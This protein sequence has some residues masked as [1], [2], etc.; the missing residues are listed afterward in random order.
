MRV[1]KIVAA[2][3]LLAVSGC[4]YRNVNAQLPSRKTII[5]QMR[6]V[7]NFQMSQ[8]WSTARRSN[9]ELVM[10]PKTWEAGAFYPGLLDAYR[11]THEKVYLNHVKQ[12][13]E[14][15]HYDHN[16]RI[17]VA[18]DIAILQTYLELYEFDRDPVYIRASRIALDSIMITP[19][20]GVREYGWCDLLF[21]GPPVWSRYYA[22]SKERKYIEY[23]DKI[24][25]EAVDN[26]KDK[27][28]HLFYRDDRF[29]TITSA[30]GKPVFWS[31]GNGWVMAGI[32][33]YLEYIPHKD[34][35]RKKYEALLS[36]MAAALK[37]LQQPDGFW[38]SNLLEPGLF[39]VGE[40]SGTVFFCYAIA[41][42]INN[43]ILSKKEFL[44]VVEKAWK[45]L[46]AAIHPDGKLGFVQPG[47]DRPN[48]TNYDLSNWYSAGGFLMAARQVCKLK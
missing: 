24:Y 19:W 41:W 7:A 31:R 9:G 35:L 20:S 39:P 29:K 2:T 34:P 12:V 5:K 47:G 36:E 14:K 8:E 3:I 45:A 42:G 26:L 27:Q 38:K 25:W 6:Q 37:P 1:R 43:G 4:L 17:H 22:I 13:A 30:E 48:T 11:Q 33:R 32:A 44:P 10:G 46:S 23:Q 21:M 28:Y 18:D 40:T 16:G 15:N